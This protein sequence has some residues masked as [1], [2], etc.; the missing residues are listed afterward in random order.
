MVKLELQRAQEVLEHRVV[1]GCS[2]HVADFKIITLESMDSIVS[3]AGDNGFVRVSSVSGSNYLININSVA[4]FIEKMILVLTA[5]ETKWNGNYG[6]FSDCIPT[7]Y[8]YTSY[9]NLGSSNEYEIVK[10]TR[11]GGGIE[12]KEVAGIDSRSVSLCKL[13]PFVLD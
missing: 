13:P 2:I 11:S 10:G 3:R 8:A 7:G 9:F 12:V 6:S 4:V 1:R 5:T